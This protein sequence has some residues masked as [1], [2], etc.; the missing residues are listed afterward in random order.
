MRISDLKSWIWENDLEIVVFLAFSAWFLFDW[1]RNGR[2]FLNLTIVLGFIVISLLYFGSQI[3]KIAARDAKVLVCGLG[4]NPPVE[5]VEGDAGI[6]RR[7]F[8]VVEVLKAPKLADLLATLSSGDFR[9][10]HILSEFADDGRLVEAQGTRADVAPL[11]ERCRTEKLLFVYF[12]WNI[13]DDYRDAVFERTHAARISHDFPLVLTIDRGA[14]F[15]LFLDNLLREIS[16]GNKLGNAWLKLRPQDAGP[17]APQPADD[18][19]PQA[20]VAL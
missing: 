6:Y 9:I 15:G 5:E 12:G 16:N 11:F 14:G 18:P 2:G 19:G 4:D 7:H 3:Y 10:L 1:N 17:G 8:P 20:V 13:P